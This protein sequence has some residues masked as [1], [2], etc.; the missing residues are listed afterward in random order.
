MINDAKWIGK[1]AGELAFWKTTPFDNDLIPVLAEKTTV[2]EGSTVYR[3]E[4]SVS[5]DV[6]RATL[7]ICG[8]G[9]Y[10]AYVNG[11]LPDEDRVMAPVQSHYYAISR[12]DTYDVTR[13]VENGKNVIAACLTGGWFA[14]AVKWWGWRMTW[15]GN[16][17]L[18]A[19]LEIE[20]ADGRTET[21]ATD[22]TWRY[23]DGYV[24]HN[25]IFD[26]EK[27]DF[28]LLDENVFRVGLDDSDWKRAALVEEPTDNL[29]ES[30]CPP[31]R[32]TRRLKPVKTIKLSD[33]QYVYDFGE[34]NSAVPHAKRAIQS[35]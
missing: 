10:V 29:V 22:E 31:V 4:F 2:D 9:Q 3:K 20:Y 16:P 18:I 15:Y 34:N 19:E 17:R 26:G 27:A 5:G 6:R 8:L 23:T 11:E 24:T 28:N 25:C 13:L 21:V 7:R 35:A 32:I 30:V 12:Y 14:P 33:T 1:K